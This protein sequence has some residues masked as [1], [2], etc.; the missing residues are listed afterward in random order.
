MARPD[1][2]TMLQSS[3]PQAGAT[4]LESQTTTSIAIGPRG[5]DLTIT[6]SFPKFYSNFQF[7]VNQRK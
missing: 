7:E 6:D 2:R 3:D 5:Q 4:S 1:I